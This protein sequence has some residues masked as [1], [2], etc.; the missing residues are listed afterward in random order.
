MEMVYV[1]AE[2]ADKKRLVATQ[3][4]VEIS[5]DITFMVFSGEQKSKSDFLKKLVEKEH[6]RNYKKEV[7]ACIKK[8]V[9]IWASRSTLCTLE[10]YMDSVQ[11]MLCEGMKDARHPENRNVQIILNGVREK[12][13]NG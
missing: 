9:N 4:K 10:E 7:E 5:D 13:K 1:D 12:V 6:K 8:Y 11:E 3:V 2:K